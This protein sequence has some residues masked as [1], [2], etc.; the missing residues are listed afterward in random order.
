MDVGILHLHT[1]VVVVFL[2]LFAFK[3][4]L[5]LANNAS[6]LTSV[7]AKTKI[8]D[9]IL[10]T[11]ILLTGG[12]LL[13][14]GGHPATWAMVKLVVVLL[15]IPAGIVGIKRESKAL[16]VIALLGFFY[17]YGVSETKSLT[18][19]RTTYSDA[20]DGAAL[21]E[22]ALQQQAAEIYRNECVRCHGED[23]AAGNYSAYNLR[24]GKLSY[25]ES[26]AVIKNG[27]GTMP[28]YGDRLS[29]KQIEALATYIERFRQ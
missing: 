29:D 25:E 20:K 28:A 12:Y 23:G 24:E 17:I 19:S 7:R 9:M 26:V 22:E 14:K 5:L 21:N 4:V 10:G 3:A 2:L 13:F 27:R 16:T 11:L 8:L 6:L 18:L 15:L 1:T